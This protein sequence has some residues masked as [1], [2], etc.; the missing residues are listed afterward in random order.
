VRKNPAVVTLAAGWRS[1]V[2]TALTRCCC[3]II[4]KYTVSQKNVHYFL[5]LSELCQISTNFN[6]LWQ[7][8]GKLDKV[9][10]YAV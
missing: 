8:D 2:L 1:F 7:V 10:S 3:N 6:K 4:G 9:V 5:F